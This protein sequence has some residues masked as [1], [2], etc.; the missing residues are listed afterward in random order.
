MLIIL[1]YCSTSQLIIAD[2]VLR[3][4]MYKEHISYCYALRK[5][6]FQ[7]LNKYSKIYSKQKIP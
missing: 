4:T 2:A 3:N 5:H 1:Y 7:K 6:S